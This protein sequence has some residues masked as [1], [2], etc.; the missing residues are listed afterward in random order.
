MLKVNK[1]EQGYG[2]KHGLKD[3]PRMTYEL[4]KRN[5][6]IM[7]STNYSESHEHV[8]IVPQRVMNSFHRKGKQY[9]YDEPNSK[10]RKGDWL[11]HV[12]GMTSNQRLHEMKIL[13]LCK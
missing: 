2:A 11:V 5:E 4:L 10:W 13:K 12:T 1:S 3:Q 6:I 7:P 8:T 9:Q